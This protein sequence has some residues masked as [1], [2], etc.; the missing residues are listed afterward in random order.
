MEAVTPS[1]TTSPSGIESALSDFTQQSE[2]EGIKENAILIGVVQ[3]TDTEELKIMTD[4]QLMQAV[5]QADTAAFETLYDRHVRGCFGLAIKIVGEPSVAEEVVQ[6]VFMKLWSRPDKFNPERGKFSGW[7]LTLVHN[8]SVDKLRRAKSGANAA[9]VPLDT[10]L[11]GGLPLSDV[12]P[13]MT[14]GPHDSAWSNQKGVL[15]REALHTLP[16]PQR[17]AITLA[18]FGG[19]TQK[20]IAEKLNEPLGTIKT[21]TRSALHQLR[22]LFESQDLAGDLR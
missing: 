19:L 12:L 18:Y 8:R 15:V 7:L 2:R 17:Q 22:R 14:P 10:S 3:D 20:E 11:D 4:D 5:G 16:E 21:R 6:D 13:D 9:G 1:N